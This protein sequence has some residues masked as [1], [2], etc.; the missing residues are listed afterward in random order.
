MSIST[1]NDTETLERA[2]GHLESLQKAASV[3]RIPTKMAINIKPLVLNKENKQFKREWQAAI[4][5][6]KRR[7]LQTVQD[8]PQR[9]IDQTQ[10][11][12]RKSTKETYRK[13]KAAGDRDRAKQQLETA[14][15]RANTERQ[16]QTKLRIKR[17]R[18]LNE[19]EKVAG[20]PPNKKAK[21]DN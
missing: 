4:H 17:K 12:I 16:H 13:L 15:K 7:L 2:T 20:K 18:E 3:G 21:L 10:T 6:S 5:D 1:I 14:L 11:E 9:V 19:K 8:H